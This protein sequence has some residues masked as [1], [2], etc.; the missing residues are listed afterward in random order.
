MNCYETLFVV[1]PTLTAEEIEGQID[2]VKTIVASEGGELKATD[3]M[4]MRRLAYPIEKNERGYYTV[5]YY[6]APSEL[7]GEL[8][9]Q[10]RYNEEILRFMT[11]KYTNKKELK[12]FEKMV[13]A[14]NKKPA[15]EKPAAPAEEEAPAA[16]EESAAPTEAPVQEN[17]AEQAAPENSEA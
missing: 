11:V 17:A 16:A 9:R 14:A 6:T 2:R 5:V 12:V 10:L 15:A 4:G 7:V 8:E 13:E 1:K 3:E